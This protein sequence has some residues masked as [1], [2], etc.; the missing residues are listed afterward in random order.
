[1][2]SYKTQNVKKNKNIIQK[3]E[4]NM[5]NKNEQGNMRVMLKFRV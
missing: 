3:H 1:M 5:V 2:F 4:R